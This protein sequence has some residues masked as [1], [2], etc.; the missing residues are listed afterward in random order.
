MSHLCLCMSFEVPLHSRFPRIGSFFSLRLSHNSLEFLCS[1]DSSPKLRIRRLP[2]TTVRILSWNNCCPR[3]HPWDFL[4]LKQLQ[5]ETVSLLAYNAR[6]QF[7]QIYDSVKLYYQPTWPWFGA[8]Y[9]PTKQQQRS[10]TKSLLTAMCKPRL[11]RACSWLWSLEAA[12]EIYDL[13]HW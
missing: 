9:L 2:E 12:S 8:T 11:A 5:E 3:F 4:H 13:L 7:R 10:T 6:V 1:P